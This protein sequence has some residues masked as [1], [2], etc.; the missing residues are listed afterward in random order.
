[1]VEQQYDVFAK[2]QTGIPQKLYKKQCLARL[3]VGIINPFSNKAE[4]II[5]DGDPSQN[6]EGCFVRVWDD[7]QQVY[8]EREN[9]NLIKKGFIIEWDGPT[10]LDS[11]SETDYSKLSTIDIVKLVNAKFL[12][13]KTI[14]N[15]I[16]SPDVVQRFLVIAESENRPEKTLDHIKQRLVELGER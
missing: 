5:L 13:L 7:M 16:N 6:H 12:T 14:L 8:F 11:E 2:M 1:M 3:E 9:K 15:K 10:D 4:R